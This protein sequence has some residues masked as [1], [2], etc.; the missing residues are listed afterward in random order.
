MEYVTS[1]GFELPRSSVELGDS[2]WF[3]LWKRKL[4]PYEE[5]QVGALLFWYETP[6]K[7]IVWKSTIRDVGRFSYGSKA[8]ARKRLVSTFGDFDSSQSYFVNAPP[9]GYC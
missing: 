3:N 5:V 4:W 1:R 7:R 9:D 2:Y 8:E 6:S